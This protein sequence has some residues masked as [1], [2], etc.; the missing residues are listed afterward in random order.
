[1]TKSDQPMITMII[2]AYN[3]EKTVRHAVESL[4]RQT[5]QDME[6]IIIEDGSTDE[7]RPILQEL[8]ASS[9]LITVIYKDIN[10]GLSA[11]R[12]SGMERARGTYIGFLDADDWMEADLLEQI[13][14][15]GI[16]KDADL[17]L[18]G[19]SHD[20]MDPQRTQVKISRQ[21]AMPSCFL[22]EKQEIV[23]YAAHCDTHKMF[24]YTWNKFYRRSDRKSTRLNSSHRS[25]SRMPS[26]A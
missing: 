17:I 18:C 20:T 24:A 2:P 3:A 10:E 8:E 5:Y 26:S 9:P 15:Q 7:T 14:R 11:G 21:V 13:Y 4:L 1:M 16:R 19:Y 12:N 25:Q 22:V 6:I 23:R